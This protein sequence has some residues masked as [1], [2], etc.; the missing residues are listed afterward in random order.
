[1]KRGLDNDFTLPPV[2]T[3]NDNNRLVRESA[4]VGD[5][6]EGTV[7]E[8]D[9]ACLSITTEEAGKLSRI[10]HFQRL[11]AARKKPGNCGR[12]G[13]P[14][15]NGYAQC[16]RCRNYHTLYKLK[17]RN[18]RFSVPSEV[19]KELFQFRRELSRLRVTVKN[20]ANERRAAYRKGYAAGL[21]GK[22]ARFRQGAYVPPP[23]SK[24]ELAT[25]S[26]AYT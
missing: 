2:E 26:H 3:I 6:H 18:E 25:I 5:V 24:Q 17:K 21:A 11:E 4:T 9:G 7:P 12:C 14:N 1:M 19:V 10:A 23:M 13:K 20:M 16:D 8:N 15:G 22:R